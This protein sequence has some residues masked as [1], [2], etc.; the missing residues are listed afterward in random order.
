MQMATVSHHSWHRA[1][2]ADASTQTMTHTDAA[3]CAATA[4]PAPVF[5]YVPPAPVIEN[6]APAPAVTFDAPSQQLPPVFS[7]ATVATDV[8]LDITGLMSLQFSSTAVEASAPQV[9]VSLPPFE[10]FTEPVYNHVHQEQIVTGEITLNI[11]EHPAVQEQLTVQEIP[12][13]SVVER[14]QELCSFTGLM[15]PQISTVSLEASQVVGSLPPVEEFAEPVCN[16]VHQE[17]IVAGEMTQNIIQNSAV[18][19]QVIVQEIPPV[20]EQ[21]QEQI[22]RDHRCDST[23]FTDGPQ[24]ELHV[25]QQFRSCVQPNH[26]LELHV[27]RQRPSWCTHEHA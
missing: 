8:N 11:V 4:S 17:Q 25:V 24:Y 18:Q 12:Q 23:D 2:R 9:V 26:Q 3:T 27:D 6:I 22:V 15:N 5:E 14:I 21:I 19:E 7:T 13:V 1:G 20:V 16:Q 10:E